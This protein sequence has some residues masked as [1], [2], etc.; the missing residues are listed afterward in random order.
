VWGPQR[1]LSAKPARTTPPATRLL[2]MDSLDSGFVLTFGVVFL[3]FALLYSHAVHYIAGRRRLK[4]TA[5]QI[6]GYTPIGELP[7]IN[8]GVEPIILLTNY[9]HAVTAATQHL[10]L[11]VAPGTRDAHLHSIDTVTLQ[12]RVRDHR[13][14]ILDL[15]ES[16]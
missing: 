2:H 7:A 5:A 14:A 8:P 1:L 6:S 10:Y 11:K 9:E 3:A 4:A 13:L 15:L 16:R 12:H